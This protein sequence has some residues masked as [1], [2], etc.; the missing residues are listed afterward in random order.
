MADPSLEVGLAAPTVVA[1]PTD[2]LFQ[3]ACSVESASEVD[4]DPRGGNVIPEAVTEDSVDVASSSNHDQQPDKLLSPDVASSST[5]SP[6]SIFSFRTVSDVW[7]VHQDGAL[8][9]DYWVYGLVL[10]TDYELYTVSRNT[11]DLVTIHTGRRYKELEW[12]REALWLEFPSTIIPPL[13][14]L[15]LEGMLEKA[16]NALG[17]EGDPNVIPALV[18][19]RMRGITLFIQWLT[20]FPEVCSSRLLQKFI[21]S[22]PD[23]FVQFQQEWQ[24]QSKKP[25][26]S[27]TRMGSVIHTLKKQIKVPP[28]WDPEITKSKQ[29]VI[30]L[31]NTLT[32]LKDNVEKLWDSIVNLCEG[33]VV[34][35]LDSSVLQADAV[36]QALVKTAVVCKRAVYSF[37]LE[38][39]E[40][41]LSLVVDLAFY[42]GLCQSCR[43]VITQ[44]DILAKQTA[45][46]NAEPE[47]VAQT[48]EL[49]NT[50][51]SEF[52]TNFRKMHVIKRSMMKSLSQNF[53]KL[54]SNMD[55]KAFPWEKHCLPLL[56]QIPDEW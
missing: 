54:S 27:R 38:N 2:D 1:A 56:E 49:L 16:D 45:E 29:F 20:K 9:L 37:S 18:T 4:G 23:E 25:L 39:E 35:R 22:S 6:N 33:Y 51:S 47:V 7:K 12:L 11:K 14:G 48:R 34:E 36:I 28:V 3:S 30:D 21:E 53:A 42:I 5:Y 44:L 26:A 31:E 17:A 40:M 24:L 15:G 19:Y 41:F 43:R 10:E 50:H 46:A 32:K 8:K 55:P 52:K 13:P